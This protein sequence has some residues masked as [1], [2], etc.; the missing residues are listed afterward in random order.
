MKFVLS[1][2]IYL[3]YYPCVM[4]CLCYDDELMYCWFNY[5]IVSYAFLL[6]INR[7][8]LAGTS[9]QSVM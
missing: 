6:Y 4:R 2:T 7:K 3:C 8:I 9:N 5:N 1:V